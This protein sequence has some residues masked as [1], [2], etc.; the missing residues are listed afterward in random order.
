AA[1]TAKSAFLANMSHELRTPLNA[2]LGYSQLLQEECRERGVEDIPADL[3]KI[4]RAGAILL[5]LLNKVLA[6]SKIEA[7]KM[8]LHPETFDLR[9][10]LQDVLASVEPLASRN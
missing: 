3:A 4:E 7:G 9:P 8:E 10:V 6:F 2:I 1:H 5:D